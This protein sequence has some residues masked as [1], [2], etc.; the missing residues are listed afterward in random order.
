MSFFV[1]RIKFTVVSEPND[2]EGE[3]EDVGRAV[4]S[5]KSILDNN[6]DIEDEDIDSKYSKHM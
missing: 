6:R 4:V 3:C 5:V 2:E 1:C